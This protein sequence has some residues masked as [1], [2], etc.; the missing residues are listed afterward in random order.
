M[1]CSNQ[2]WEIKASPEPLE[3]LL[4]LEDYQVLPTKGLPSTSIQSGQ[5]KPVARLTVRGGGRV[6]I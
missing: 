5:G 2:T 3:L 1:W 6:G 4:L